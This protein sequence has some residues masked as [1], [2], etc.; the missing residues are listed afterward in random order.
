MTLLVDSIAVLGALVLS[1][2]FS[3]LETAAYSSSPI[4]LQHR[5][6]EG[7]GFAARALQLL[8]NLSG[9]VTTTLIGNNLTVYLGTFFLTRR[10]AGAEISNA[11]IVATLC[12]TP[13]YFL[14]AE[15]LPKR[16]AHARADDYL[17]ASA[18]TARSFHLAFLPFG[19]LLA[20]F[21]RSLQGMLRR[22]WGAALEATGRQ[23]LFEHLEAG[24]AEG[25][26]NE[27][28]H[29]MVRRVLDLEAMEIGDIMIPF[30][31]ALAIRENETCREA[32]AR[33]VRAGHRRAPV[34]DRSGRPLHRLVALN[35]ILRRPQSLEQPVQDVAQEALTLDA[36]LTVTRALRKMRAENARLVIVT[37]RAGRAVGVL[38]L[39]DILSYVAGALRL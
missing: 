31:E 25:L 18:R 28:Q 29:R 21:A 37:G 2:F 38:T 16:L 22:W 1:A 13:V 14:F 39:S 6:G 26:L 35:A 17:S 8:K 7:D 9:L 10:L 19:F 24:L 36:R 11:E 4:R 12:L 30:A 15:S 3:G 23:M 33:M 5:A 34:L 20:G 27:R 32:L